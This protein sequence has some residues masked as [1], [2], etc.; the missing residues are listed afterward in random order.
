M[1]GESD[2]DEA[3]GGDGV[4]ESLVDYSNDWTV[5]ILSAALTEDVA[6]APQRQPDSIIWRDVALALMDGTERGWVEEATFRLEKGKFAVAWVATDSGKR[7]IAAY[8]RRS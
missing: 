6:G 5:R 1:L 4:K 2:G 7:A 8:R 3:I